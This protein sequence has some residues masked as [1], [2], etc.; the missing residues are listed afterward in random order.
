[1]VYKT[2]LPSFLFIKPTLA[3]LPSLLQPTCDLRFCPSSL[4]RPLPQHL[5]PLTP[6]IPL[7]FTP[8]D[9][10]RNVKSLLLVVERV[11]RLL[12]RLV[13][14]SQS[15]PLFTSSSPPAHILHF[16]LTC[17]DQL[18]MPA[19]QI[20][21]SFPNVNVLRPLRPVDSIQPMYLSS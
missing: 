18:D 17:S 12:D 6:L 4:L 19:M 7:I 20:L 8:V 14:F 3:E 15:D 21:A 2:F 13:L 11:A 5:W 9:H 10:F 1:M 16:P